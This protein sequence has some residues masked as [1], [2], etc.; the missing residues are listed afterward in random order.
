MPKPSVSVLCALHLNRQSLRT[1][2]G[3]YQKNLRYL[4][5]SISHDSSDLIV[6]HS[7]AV[8]DR[9]NVFPDRANQNSIREP[10]VAGFRQPE[11]IISWFT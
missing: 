8:N 6:D 2:F 3:K 7:P 10:G 11:T 9:V 4:Q 5:K 1:R